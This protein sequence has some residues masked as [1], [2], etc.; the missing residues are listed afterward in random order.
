MASH[1]CPHTLRRLLRQKRRETCTK[2]RCKWQM[3]LTPFSFQLP[4]TFLCSEHTQCQMHSLYQ[5]LLA[6][7]LDRACPF[8]LLFHPSHPPRRRNGAGSRLPSQLLPRANFRNPST[9]RKHLAAF[10]GLAAAC[11]LAS[12]TAAPSPSKETRTHP[13]TRAFAVSRDIT[14]SWPFMGPTA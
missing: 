6:I 7:T 1:R 5:M 8:H 13:S 2:L 10:V 12:R 11:S 9:G 14:R 4:H 3:H